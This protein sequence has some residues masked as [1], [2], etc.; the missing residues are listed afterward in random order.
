M[1]EKKEFVFEFVC[2]ACVHSW[3]IKAGFFDVEVGD[4]EAVSHCPSVLYFS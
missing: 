4:V 1:E 2:C 3:V